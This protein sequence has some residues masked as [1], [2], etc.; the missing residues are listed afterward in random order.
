MI[1]ADDIRAVIEEYDTMK[2]RIGMTA[3]PQR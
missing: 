2:L 1:S 3:S